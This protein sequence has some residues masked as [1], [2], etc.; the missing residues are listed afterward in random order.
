LDRAGCDLPAFLRG[1]YEQSLAGF[2]VRLGDASFDGCFA[3]GHGLPARVIVSEALG[4]TEVPG[5][6][7]E[8]NTEDSA[9]AYAPLSDRE[10]EVARL[11]ARGLKNREIAESLVL[12]ERTI[13]SHLERIF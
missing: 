5:T 3:A 12:A 8:R 7:T 2:R 10:W 6:S 13:G 9:H 11:V 4:V 1:Q